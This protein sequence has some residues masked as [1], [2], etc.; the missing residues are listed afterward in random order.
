MIKVTRRQIVDSE[1]ITLKFSSKEEALQLLSNLTQK[2]IR[3]AS[4]VP[5]DYNTKVVQEGINAFKKAK[6][7]EER[8]DALDNLFVSY[9]GL[10]KKFDFD[11]YSYNESYNA[12]Q[13]VVGILQEL[14]S[15]WEKYESNGKQAEL[16]NQAVKTTNRLGERFGYFPGIC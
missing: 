10:T 3:V 13:M 11:K 4:P 16:F 6:T 12:E 2:K 8:Q 14:M 7:D 5:I 1:P 9:F 15:D